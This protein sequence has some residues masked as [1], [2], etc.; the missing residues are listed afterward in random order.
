MIKYFWTIFLIG[1]V[2][3]GPMNGTP[4]QN[5]STRNAPSSGNTVS[6]S[7]KESHFLVFISNKIQNS[8]IVPQ[9]QLGDNEYVLRIAHADLRPLSPEAQVTLTYEMPD[10]P[11]MGQETVSATHESDG[12]FKATLFFSMSGLW[13]ISLK[14]KDQWIEDTYVFTESVK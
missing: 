11:Q 7:S 4:P 6:Q 12:T 14:I 5:S 2:G 13:E 9:T 1:L 8:F 3:C 10:M